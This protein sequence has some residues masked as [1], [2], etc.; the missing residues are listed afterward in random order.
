MTKPKLN[1]HLYGVNYD[2]NSIEEGVERLGTCD[3]PGGD[4]CDSECS[5]CP[6]FRGTELGLDDIGTACD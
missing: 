3:F 4:D 6:Y 2:T 1:K 5:E